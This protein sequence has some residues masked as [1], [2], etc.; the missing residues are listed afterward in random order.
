M[1][2][3]VFL[4]ELRRGGLL[5][6]ATNQPFP[7]FQRP[8]ADFR[9]KFIPLD[10]AHGR[11]NGTHRLDARDHHEVVYEFGYGSFI[12]AARCDYRSPIFPLGSQAVDGAGAPIH[13]RL[14]LGAHLEDVIGAAQDQAVGLEDLGPDRLVLVLLNAFPFLV[15]CVAGRAGQDRIPIEYDCLRCGALALSAFQHN[16]RESRRIAFQPVRAAH[17]GYDFH[18]LIPSGKGGS[19]VSVL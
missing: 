1:K 17:D 14:Q 13:E 2:G 6:P 4:R 7:K 10:P 9:R 12:A 19:V 5:A 18:M 11:P 3:P 15:A 16:A 8:I